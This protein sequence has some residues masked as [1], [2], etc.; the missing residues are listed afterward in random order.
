[1]AAARP[2]PGRCSPPVPGGRWRGGRFGRVP[3]AVSGPPRD[4]VGCPGTSFLFGMRGGGFRFEKTVDAPF[5]VRK[6]F[7]RENAPPAPP[8]PPQSPV[9]SAVSP[10]NEPAS[11]GRCLLPGKPRPQPQTCPRP[12]GRARLDG[13]RPPKVDSDGKAVSVVAFSWVLPQVTGIRIERQRN[14]SGYRSSATGFN[15]AA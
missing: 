4:A 5:R 15:R 3:W 14:V 10:N 11:S 8:A 9:A 1:M 6:E 7:H 13:R 12:P 2:A